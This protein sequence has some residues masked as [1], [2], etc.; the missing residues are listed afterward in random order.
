MESLVLSPQNIKQIKGV[1]ELPASKS[2]ANRVLT[3]NFLLNGKLETEISAGSEDI[4]VLKSA[5]ENKDGNIDLKMA[6]TAFRFLTAA[7][8]AKEGNYILNGSHRLSQRPI[9]ALVYALRSTGADISYQKEGQNLP[10][11]IKGK[12]LQGGSLKM[13]QQLSSQF[14]SALML[15]AEINWD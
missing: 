3:L 14:I 9:A 5:I 2:I 13:Q 12:K 4:Q 8:S 15:I 10:L 1:A 7:C 11:A 6:G